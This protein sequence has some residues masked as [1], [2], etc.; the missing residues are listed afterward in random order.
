M[1]YYSV[2]VEILVEAEDADEARDMVENIIDEAQSSN[3]AV[4]DYKLFYKNIKKV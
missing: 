2:K 3:E 1:K 4:Q